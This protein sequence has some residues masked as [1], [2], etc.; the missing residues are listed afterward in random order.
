LQTKEADLEE[1]NTDSLCR[2]TPSENPDGGG[3]R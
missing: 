1:C 2:V 3:P